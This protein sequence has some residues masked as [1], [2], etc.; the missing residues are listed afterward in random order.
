MDR[1]SFAD[2]T[3]SLLDVDDGHIIA[4]V[5]TD[6]V[7][8]IIPTS[9]QPST[10]QTSFADTVARLLE[11]SPPDADAPTNAELHEESHEAIAANDPAEL[12]LDDADITTEFDNVNSSCSPHDIGGSTNQR[13]CGATLPDTV[14]QSED[15]VDEP[16]YYT[17][18]DLFN[19]SPTPRSESEFDSQATDAEE[20]MKPDPPPLETKRKHWFDDPDFWDGVSRALGQSFDEPWF[21]N[22][23]FF[24]AFEFKPWRFEACVDEILALIRDRFAD[25]STYKIGITENPYS[26]WWRPDCGYGHPKN[27]QHRFSKMMLVYAAPTSKPKHAESSGSMEREL[28]KYC[29]SEL[30][31]SCLNRPGGGGDCPSNGSPHFVYIVSCELGISL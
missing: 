26:R 30:D 28:I 13:D 25:G 11:D 5:I 10:R 6:P 8:A 23:F 2:V 3:K 16:E 22:S 7:D 12:I 27:H 1:P 21:D 19:R 15:P 24:T 4:N 17:L 20:P 31:S 18:L 9:P 14:V 29:N